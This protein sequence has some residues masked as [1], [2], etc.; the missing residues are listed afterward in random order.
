M[1][2]SM[3]SEEIIVTPKNS[4]L[5]WI[6]GYKFPRSCYLLMIILIAGLV[7][8]PL[9]LLNLNTHSMHPITKK[10]IKWL[11]TFNKMSLMMILLVMKMN[12]LRIAGEKVCS[13]MIIYSE[14]IKDSISDAMIIRFWCLC[15]KLNILIFWVFI[16]IYIY[17]NTL[18]T[19][20][21]Y[22]YVYITLLCTLT[23][24]IYIH[25]TMH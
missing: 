10:I 19:N 5:H 9:I 21:L 14:A 6:N 18:Y 8:S 2:K 12:T 23:F 20:I 13:L 22:I 16:Y 17:Y 25:S 7:H 4:R 3:Q 11:K 1:A 24:Y 15:T